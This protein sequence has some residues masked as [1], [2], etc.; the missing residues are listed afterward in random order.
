MSLPLLSIKNLTVGYGEKPILSGINLDVFK[1]DFIG[2][3]GPN[4]GGKTTL[5]KAIVGLIK[6]VEGEIVFN[7]KSPVGYL[8]QMNQHDNRFPIPVNEVVLSGLFGEKG[9]FKRFTKADFKKAEYWLEFAGIKGFAKKK[10]G[11][12]SG[13][14]RQRVLLCRA[15]ISDPDLLILDEPNTFVDNKFEGELYE[16]LKQLNETKAIM[17]VSHD[18]GTIS[19]Y[20]K[21]IAC[22]NRDLH[23][24]K[25]NIITQ[26][27][28]E[29]YNCP[30][31]L[32][33]HG[34][35]PHTVLLNHDEL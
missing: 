29:S 1:N 26:Q 11:S 10:Y 8:P 21:S 13:G 6:P 22:V 35:V 14:E 24:H 3:V 32:I 9:I 27:Q 34:T 33:T 7:T 23:H 19:T 15:L 20:V 2:I 16:L 18:L 4:G 17:I 5:L 12:L 31:Q 25:S 30:I 28:L